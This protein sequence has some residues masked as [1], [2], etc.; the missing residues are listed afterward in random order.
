MHGGMHGGMHGANRAIQGGM[1]FISQPPFISIII[2]L[3]LLG[4]YIISYISILVCR[5]QVCGRP[6]WPPF[7][8]YNVGLLMAIFQV[9][10]KRVNGH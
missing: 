5:F 8:F 1:Q 7:F 4:L 2:V 3:Y 6:P 10:F 9:G